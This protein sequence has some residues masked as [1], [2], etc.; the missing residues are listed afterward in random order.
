VVALKPSHTWWAP[1]AALGAVWE[2][3][4][5]GGWVSAV[6]PG[7]WQPVIRHFHDGHTERWWALEGEA[8]PYGPTRPRRL[9]I[10]TPDPATLPEAA[11]WYLETTLPADAADLAEVVRLYGL[12]HWV[13]QAYK[14]VK[15]SLGW[16]QYQVRSD[17]AMRRHWALVQ[18][19]FAF[20]WWAETPAPSPEA[21]V[22]VGERGG[23]GEPPGAG[24][25]PSVA[26]LAG[27]TAP[28]ARLAGASLGAVALLARLERP[29]AAATAAG[30]ARL[31]PPGPPAPPL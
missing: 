23:K 19:A 1:V 20:C 14:Q 28:G 31:A 18:C 16:S 3:A 15:T 22:A 8:G 9:A 4:A 29:A 13:E 27:G 25:A 10:A 17:T 21:A 24:L 11:T 7:A 30:A 5:A 6:Q 12:R 2:V 26:L